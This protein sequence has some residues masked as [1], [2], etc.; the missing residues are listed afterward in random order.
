[1]DFTDQMAAKLLAQAVR[2]LG[3]A[4]NETLCMQPDREV[5]RELVAEVKETLG[6][7]ASAY[8]RA[9]AAAAGPTSESGGSD[10]RKP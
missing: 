7:F 10:A 9:N 8:F 5:V 3:L 1:M 4:L 6:E 2:N